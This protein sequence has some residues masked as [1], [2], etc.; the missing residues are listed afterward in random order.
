MYGDE[1]CPVQVSPCAGRCTL[2]RDA[3]IQEH[4]AGGKDHE[5]GRQQQAVVQQRGHSAA[6]SRAEAAGHDAGGSGGFFFGD[7]TGDSAGA[8]FGTSN[9]SSGRNTLS[10]R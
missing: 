1:S 2:D 9:C 10:K 4:G 7:G 8:G 5:Q 3:M 6:E